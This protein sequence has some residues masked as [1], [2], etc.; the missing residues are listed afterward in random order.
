LIAVFPEGRRTRDGAIG[1]FKTGAFRLALE[2]GAPVVPVCIDGGFLAMPRGARRF[3]P[4]RLAVRVLKPLGADE[5][6]GDV[7]ER[8][9]PIVRERIL[10]AVSGEGRG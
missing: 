4:A 5:M 2:A 3:R 10:A 9:A 6:T 1:V 8:V 7:K